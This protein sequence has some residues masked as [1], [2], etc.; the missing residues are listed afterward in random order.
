MLIIY[1]LALVHS[2]S[3]PVVSVS[4]LINQNNFYDGKTVVVEGEAIGD[5]ML[6]GK[7]G[8]V[9]ISDGSNA[10]GI[11]ADSSRLS[12]IKT[13]G[14]YQTKGDIVRV[15]GTFYNYCPVHSGETD[16][17]AVDLKV[18]KNGEIK[19][20][21]LNPVR[22]HLACGLAFAAMAILLLRQILRKTNGGQP[23]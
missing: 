22:L 6:R 19:K 10:L 12:Q 11:Y 20:E 4:D 7:S 13:L 3:L 16:L 5:L 15:D 9:N 8:W 1:F 17:H 21:I 2:A 23:G 18:V 14:R